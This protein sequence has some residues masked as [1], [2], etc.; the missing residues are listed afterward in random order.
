[1][2]NNQN[3]MGGP[4][5]IAPQ[6]VKPA[7]KGSKPVN[8]ETARVRGSVVQFMKPGLDSVSGV[9]ANAFDLQ[10]GGNA[11]VGDVAASTASDASGDNA[12]VAV[13]TTKDGVAVDEEVDVV[14]EGDCYVRV[15]YETG[16]A[17]EEFQPLYLVD[18][19]DFLTANASLSGQ[20]DVG[21]KVG[22]IL[23]DVAADA[24][25]SNGAALT[26]ALIRGLPPFV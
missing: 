15:Y 16:V 25:A 24:K 13:V 17:V 10:T 6:D 7:G 11:N 26:R 14:V 8:R 1:M 18:G 9:D 20:G 22:I 23:E 4:F 2:T 21:R 12:F 3:N 5:I 19:Q